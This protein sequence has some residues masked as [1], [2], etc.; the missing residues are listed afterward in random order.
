MP[1]HRQCSRWQIKAEANRNYCYT[2]DKINFGL[3]IVIFFQR[4]ARETQHIYKKLAYTRTH[5]WQVV[6]GTTLIW[7]LSSDVLLVQYENA[8][9]WFLLTTR[10]MPVIIYDAIPAQVRVTSCNINRSG[11][12][13]WIVCHLW[14]WTSGRKRVVNH[15]P[16]VTL[17]LLR[18]PKAEDKEAA[19]MARELRVSGCWD[20]LPGYLE[21]LQRQ[22]QK[23]SYETGCLT[24]DISFADF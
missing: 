1:S 22:S 9:K 11:R 8:A 20:K 4:S 2:V 24:S 3:R 5:S 23:I 12:K 19:N 16:P 17:S 6:N 14:Y 15:L 18:S 7:L 10:C 13:V 21:H